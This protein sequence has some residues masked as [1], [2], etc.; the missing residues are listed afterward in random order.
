[1][2]RHMKGQM[3]PQTPTPEAAQHTQVRPADTQKPSA[4]PSP[5][6]DAPRNDAG[7][8]NV[9][10][11]IP[12]KKPHR[13]WP[14]VLLLIVIIVCGV[15]FIGRFVWPDFFNSIPVIG[16]VFGTQNEQ[17]VED[18]NATNPE[19]TEGEEGDGYEKPG[20]PEHPGSITEDQTGSVQAPDGATYNLSSDLRSEV[21]LESVSDDG[22][23]LRFMSDPEAAYTT[24]HVTSCE[25][26]GEAIDPFAEPAQI[27]Y[28]LHNEFTGDTSETPDPYFIIS[29]VDGGQDSTTLT[30]RMD[31]FTAADYASVKLGIDQTFAYGR[32][33]TGEYDVADVNGLFVEITRA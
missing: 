25:V 8:A 11:D 14:L 15:L 28:T 7:N 2:A 4:T 27:H 29:P 9:N 12:E 16:D 6:E 19:G 10:L 5:Y 31:G 32:L 30:I 18:E 24:I 22:I 3:D 23:V 33:S 21:K 17:P 26:N 1:M 20:I 13:K